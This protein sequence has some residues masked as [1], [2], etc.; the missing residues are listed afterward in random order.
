MSHLHVLASRIECGV[1]LLS[2]PPP[3][4][5]DEVAPLPARGDP[6]EG[7]VREQRL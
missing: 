4:A 7:G 3:P 6:G 1:P 2:D 5:A